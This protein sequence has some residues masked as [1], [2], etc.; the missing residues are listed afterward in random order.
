M[1]TERS[2]ILFC[3]GDSIVA[4]LP[5]REAAGFTIVN[6]GISGAGVRTFLHRAENILPP[7]RGTTVL[8]AIG[9][10]DASA[11]PAFAAL[12]WEA[13][14]RELCTQLAAGAAR[15]IAQTALPVEKFQPWGDQLFFVEHINTINAII[16]RL[17]KEQGYC[18]IDM[19][20]HFADK[21]G[22]MPPGGTTD[23]VH[24]TGASYE[25]WREYWEEQLPHCRWNRSHLKIRF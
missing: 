9:V 20:A 14:Y 13:E 1:K 4:G 22:F 17:A 21:D 24:L 2:T 3:V 11:G 10:N 23:G 8:L 7:E 6:A 5:L 18:L 15:F 12:A 16:R 25:K 19:H